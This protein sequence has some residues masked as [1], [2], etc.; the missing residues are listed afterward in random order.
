MSLRS[1]NIKLAYQGLKA[2]KGRSFLTM[3]GIVVGVVSVI[4]IAGVGQGVKDQVAGQMNRYG[5]DVVLITPGAVNSGGLL[6]GLSQGSNPLG[7]NDLQVIQKVPGVQSVVPV[8]LTNGSIK[9]DH[10][11]RSPL[12]V[13]TTADFQALIN[14]KMQYGGF[15]DSTSDSKTV[16]L[17]DSIAH[18][19]FNDNAPLG[20]TLTWRGQ[21]FIVA[22]VFDDFAAPPFSPEADYNNAVFIPFD[23][24]RTTTGGGL[25]LQQILAK[26]ANKDEAVRVTGAIQSALSKTHGGADDF[27]VTHAGGYTSKDNQTLRL[28]GFLVAGAAAVALI[29]GGVGIMNVM[30]V[31][32]AE[33][34]HEIGLRKAIGA[35]N[36]QILRQFMAEAFVLCLAGSVLGI[37]VGL[38]CIG[39]LRVYSNVEAVIVWQALVIAPAAA[40]VVGMFFGTMP[41]LK[42][43]RKDPIDALRHE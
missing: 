37:L 24:A 38:A 2:A 39:L 21:Q 31:S 18:K 16:V 30:L 17:G 32:V 3:L 9:A 12:I 20:E 25:G 34:M 13:A 19:L 1:D 42:A 15:F 27:Q 28:L 10:T 11:L 23:T 29:V 14:V 6:A 33:R 43:A 41:A 26:T 8:A 40:I 36:Q 4:L 35:T 7:S 5:K 22:G